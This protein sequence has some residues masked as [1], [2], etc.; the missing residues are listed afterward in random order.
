MSPFTVSIDVKKIRLFPNN[1]GTGEKDGIAT[2]LLIGV[3]TFKYQDFQIPKHLGKKVRQ[4]A[5]FPF[6]YII[7]IDKFPFPYIIRIDK[8]PFPYISSSFIW[9]TPM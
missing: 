1:V 5:K 8:F 6:P 7:R 2:I 4:F 3:I 9:N